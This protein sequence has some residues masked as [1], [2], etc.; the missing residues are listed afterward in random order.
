MPMTLLQLPV[1]MSATSL[2]TYTIPANSGAV[3]SLPAGS[4]IIT[5]SSNLFTD[6]HGQ[7]WLRHQAIFV[8][9]IAWSSGQQPA[10]TMGSETAYTD[11]PMP[12]STIDPVT[13]GFK[14]LMPFLAYPTTSQP[15]SAKPKGTKPTKAT[16]AKATPKKKSLVK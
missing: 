11:V 10:F 2:A 5:S 8:T 6:E 12:V 1:K 14:E 3:L 13:A 7:Y 4:Y 15:K 16:P 9:R